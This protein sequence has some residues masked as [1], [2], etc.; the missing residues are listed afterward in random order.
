M[1]AQYT[2]L[3]H[4]CM[5]MGKEMV[6]HRHAR[7]ENDVRQED[8]V[9]ANPHTWPNHH[10]SPHMRSRANLCRRIDHRG[11]MNALGIGRGLVEHPQC[12]RKRM[13]RVLNPQRGRRNLWKLRL[14]HHRCGLCRTRQPG[15]LGVGD[16][17]NL[18]RPCLF[19]PLHP[20]HF[21]TRVAAQFR[22][23]VRCQLAKFHRV[24]CTGTHSE[25]LCG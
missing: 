17:R 11:R 8:R 5:R 25:R 13:I 7:V 21:H 1:V 12:P 18:R 19:N 20:S 22:A 23:Q 16:K 2:V 24:D 3:T 9:L 10:V 4:H 6:S 15:I 14:H